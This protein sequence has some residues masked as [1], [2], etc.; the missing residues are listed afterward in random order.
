MVAC[1][2][3][4]GAQPH[5]ARSQLNGGM[6]QAL[7]YGCSRSACSTPTSASFLNANFEDYKI[8]GVQEIPEMVVDPRRRGHRAA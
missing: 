5:D 1:K 3:A 2:T 7:S 6:V 4:A 8:A